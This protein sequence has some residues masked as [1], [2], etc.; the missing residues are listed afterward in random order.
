MRL[1]TLKSSAGTVR[2]ARPASVK[3]YSR[4]KSATQLP[5]SAVVPAVGSLSWSG[6]AAGARIPLVPEKANRSSSDAFTGCLLLKT[7]FQL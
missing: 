6:E 3:S 7:A 1:A 5:G 4:R 2:S